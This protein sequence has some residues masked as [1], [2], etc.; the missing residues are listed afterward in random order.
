M[1]P[2]L[3]QRSNMSVADLHNEIKVLS[4]EEKLRLIE[5]L[6]DSISSEALASAPLTS[7]EI[8]ELDRRVAEYHDDPTTG[9]ALE[10]LDEFL[11]I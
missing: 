8:D 11:G 2:A 5:V 3:G 10:D 4:P 1:V 9:I 7:D 6:W